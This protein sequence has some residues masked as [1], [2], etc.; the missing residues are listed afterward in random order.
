MENCME[1]HE[2]I[3]GKKS[4]RGNIS[5]ATAG[6]GASV[7]EFLNMYMVPFKIVIYYVRLKQFARRFCCL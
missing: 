7:D 6:T 1:L 2:L 3:T 5:S 4:F